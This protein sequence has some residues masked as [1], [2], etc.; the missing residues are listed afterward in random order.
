MG[1]CA[2]RPHAIFL[3]R[4]DAANGAL[5]ARGEFLAGLV[6]SACGYVVPSAPLGAGS[7]HS[8]RLSPHFAQ[9][10]TPLVGRENPKR[11]ADVESHSNVAKNATLEWGTHYGKGAQPVRTFDE[12]TP[13]SVTVALPAGMG[14]F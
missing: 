5:R 6:E 2:R 3:L 9:D 4:W 12:R 10:D 14:S 13:C 1:Y 7:L 8:V 11:S